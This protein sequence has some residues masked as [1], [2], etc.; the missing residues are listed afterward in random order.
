[1]RTEA[2]SAQVQGNGRSGAAGSRDLAVESPDG[3]HR[4][5]V[6]ELLVGAAITV[7]FA[8]AAV[9]WHASSTERT[10]VVTAA[11]DLERGE[12]ITASDLRVVHIGADDAV[13]S[14]PA[15]RS[16]ELIGRI[17][18]ADIQADSL[19]T[20]GLVSDVPALAPGEGIVGLALDPGQ[21]PAIRLAPGDVVSVVAPGADE[22]LVL[23]EG[24]VVHAVEELGGQG[25]RLVSVRAPEDKILVVAA[26]A[27][28]GPLRIVLVGR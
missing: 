19:L 18:S 16:S 7:A 23:V 1:M 28:R 21:Y 4:V 26:A 27:E 12:V 24:A 3:R 9:L 17:A 8:L 5:R 11:V 10:P 15:G 6:P 22:P 20:F 13:A 2:R 14:V 25:R